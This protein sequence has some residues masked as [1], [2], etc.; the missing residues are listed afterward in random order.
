MYCT[1][2]IH[3]F[4]KKMSKPF[5]RE[6]IHFPGQKQPHAGTHVVD[7]RVIEAAASETCQRTPHTESQQTTVF[8]DHLQSNLIYNRFRNSSL[9]TFRH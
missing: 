4:G 1:D 3:R 5:V 8:T 2:V 9:K 7:E 6:L